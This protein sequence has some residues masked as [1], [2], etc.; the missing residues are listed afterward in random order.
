MA[1]IADLAHRLGYRVCAHAEGVVGCAAAIRH[2]VDTV[3]HGMYLHSRP[4]LLGAMAAA[5]R[6]LVRPLSGYCT[7]MSGLGSEVIDPAH[8]DA[9][10]D[11]PPILGG[12][13]RAGT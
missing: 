4:D 13:G 8:A 11:M 7:W 3:E 1:A 2:G 6:V 12:T 9:E 5:G 10:P